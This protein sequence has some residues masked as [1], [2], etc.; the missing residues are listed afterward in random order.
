MAAFQAQVGSGA[1]MSSSVG[2]QC[3]ICWADGHTMAGWG[4]YK[5]TKKGRQRYFCQS[6]L[7]AQRRNVRD[8]AATEIMLRLAADLQILESTESF[9]CL[10]GCVTC[11]GADYDGDM[12][13]QM[14]RSSEEPRRGS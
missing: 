1:W 14:S 8:L 4:A 7:V 2:H 12:S 6:C 9:I 11:V 10:A 3:N 5:L 13:K